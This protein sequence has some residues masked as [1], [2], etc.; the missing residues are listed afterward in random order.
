MSTLKVNALQDT[1]GNGYYP[2]RAWINFNGT[3]T[4]AIRNDGNVS[5]ITDNGTGDYTCAFSSS[6]A[7][8][9]YAVSLGGN[10]NL[11]TN[12][13]RL[14]VYLT[15]SSYMLTSSNRFLPKSSRGGGQLDNQDHSVIT[16]TWSL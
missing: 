14:Q 16:L 1:S 11:N 3:G 10:N 8:S 7:H 5:S 2:A 15:L 4:V 13:N 12:A 9:N 6:F